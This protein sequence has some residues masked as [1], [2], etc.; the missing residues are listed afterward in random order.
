MVFEITKPRASLYSFKIPT[1]Q[2]NNLSTLILSSSMWTTHDTTPWNILISQIAM[3]F[4]VLLFEE[5]A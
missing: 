5:V 4:T 3:F 1:S 2:I